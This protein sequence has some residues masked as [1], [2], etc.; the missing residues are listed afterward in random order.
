MVGCTSRVSDD[1]TH[2]LSTLEPSECLPNLPDHGE[3]LT[4]LCHSST[5]ASLENKVLPFV[6]QFDSTRLCFQDKQIQQLY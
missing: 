2:C 5:Y 4:T 6:R 1:C 3:S